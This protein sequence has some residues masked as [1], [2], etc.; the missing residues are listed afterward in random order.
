MISRNIAYKKRFTLNRLC[1]LLICVFYTWYF[2]PICSAFLWGGKFKIIFFGLF[3]IGCIGLLLINGFRLNTITIAILSYM[4]FFLILYVLGIGD[5]NRH[6]R[7][8]FTFWGTPLVFFGLLNKDEQLRIG[9]YLT[10]LFVIT[11]ITSSY[12]VVIDNAAARTLAHAGSESELQ[13]AYLIRNI[14]SISLFQGLV[15]FVPILICLPRTR[16]FRF[17]GVAVVCIIFYVLTNAS[18]TISLFVFAIALVLSTVFVGYGRKRIVVAEICLLSAIIIWVN[19]ATILNFLSSIIDNYK[20]TVRL[21]ELASFFAGEGLGL[22]VG[23]RWEHYSVSIMTFLNNPFG[24]GP[25]YSY[26]PLENGIGYHS[27]LFDDL[28]RFGILSVAFYLVL[29]TGYYKYLREE[30]KKVGCPQVAGIITVIYL[31]FL[32]FNLG[33]RAADESILTMFI[34]PVI[35]SMIDYCKH[36]G[37]FSWLKGRYNK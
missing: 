22:N 21:T 37:R 34:L 24:V 10:V 19:A 13:F 9:V 14:S 26:I 15:Y 3:A 35:P 7:I 5:T 2:L 29:F 6:I 20:I 32:S 11:A 27:K 25:Y 4:V 30:W 12:G 28:A 23:L 36:T 31:L 8:S 18:F 1:E 17:V 33:F 16:K